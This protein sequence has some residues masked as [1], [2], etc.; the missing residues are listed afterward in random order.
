MSNKGYRMPLNPR[1]HEMFLN[2]WD[3]CSTLSPKLDDADLYLLPPRI[4]SAS[5]HPVLQELHAHIGS[6]EGTS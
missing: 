1:L 6:I 4:W 3:H 5:N 2:I